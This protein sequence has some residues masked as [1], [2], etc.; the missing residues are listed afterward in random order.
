[1]VSQKLGSEARGVWLEY[2]L[3]VARVFRF[4]PLPVIVKAPLEDVLRTS[5]DAAVRAFIAY[6]R[7]QTAMLKE[8]GG[9]ASAWDKA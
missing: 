4:A 5:D 6:V 1:M 2:G 9:D 7:R 8:R 3:E